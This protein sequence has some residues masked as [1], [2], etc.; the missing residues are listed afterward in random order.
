MSERVQGNEYMP[1]YGLHHKDTTTM[2]NLRR[3]IIFNSVISKVPSNAIIG[4]ITSSWTRR[5]V[6]LSS[7]RN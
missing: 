5:R 6:G 7:Q 2:A 1:I 4:T 3:I